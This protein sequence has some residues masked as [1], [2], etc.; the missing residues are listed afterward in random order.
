[1]ILSSTGISTVSTTVTNRRRCLRLSCG[2]MSDHGFDDGENLLLFVAS[3]SGNG[4]ELS[5]ELRLGAALAALVAV[6]DARDF[7]H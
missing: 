4:F 3:Q 2:V 5:F 1:M 7:F 6:V